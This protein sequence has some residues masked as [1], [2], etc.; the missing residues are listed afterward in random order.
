MRRSK[1]EQKR[2][3]LGSAKATAC[4]RLPKIHFRQVALTA[5]EFVP[6]VIDDTDCANHLTSRV[7]GNRP[8]RVRFQI[9]SR[10][11]TNPR[12]PTDRA[13]KR[14]PGLS[15]ATPFTACR[16]SERSERGVNPACYT[17]Y[18]FVPTRQNGK[19]SS[20][21]SNGDLPLAGV[22]GGRRRTS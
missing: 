15:Q 5:E 3:E 18:H 11:L 2:Q 21:T 4:R 7:T 10:R 6:A 16:A 8:N 20:S 22:V 13:A 12:E 17:P 9:T 19:S 14:V 1:L